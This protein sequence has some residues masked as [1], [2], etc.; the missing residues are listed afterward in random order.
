[1]SRYKSDRRVLK[2]FQGHPSKTSCKIF[3]KSYKQICVYKSPKNIELYTIHCI[4]YRLLCDTQATYRAIKVI[5]ESWK[6]T[7]DVLIRRPAT[8]VTVSNRLTSINLP[9]TLN[10]I[11]YRLLF[12]TYVPYHAIKVITE[13]W[14]IP[15]DVLMRRPATYFATVFNWLTSTNLTQTLN[16]TKDRLFCVKRATYRVIEVIDESWKKFQGRPNVTSFNI[17]CKGFKQIDV[18]KFPKNIELST[19]QGIICHPGAISRNKSDHRVLKKSQGRPNETSSDI[20]FIS[21]KQIAI[22]IL[23]A[24]LMTLC[25][26]LMKN[27]LQD[28]S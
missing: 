15:K 14:K 5:V 18:Y 20:F 24:M 25:L 27:M 6:S 3:C 13:S 19:I 16:K 4:E 28:V 10:S 9:K 22:N 26:K 7:K 23:G 2:K 8:V 1:M 11:Q 17:F 21:F 12:V